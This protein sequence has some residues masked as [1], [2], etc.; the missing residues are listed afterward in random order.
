MYAIRSYYD[1]L[2][3]DRT[4]TETARGLVDVYTNADVTPN[5]VSHGTVIHNNIFYTKYETVSIN[6]MD[7][8]SLTA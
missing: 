1:T 5:S 2:Y 7:R 3:Q 8:E 6:I 4:T